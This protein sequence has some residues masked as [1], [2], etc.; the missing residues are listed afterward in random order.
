[1]ALEHKDGGFLSRKLLI[2]MVGFGIICLTWVA[3]AFWP[4]LDP[5]YGTL[6]GGIIGLAGLYMTGNVANSIVVGK[7]SQKLEKED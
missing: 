1:M 3:T 5:Q 2:T 4:A 7:T 6:V